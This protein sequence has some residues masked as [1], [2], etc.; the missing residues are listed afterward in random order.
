MK[1]LKRLTV[2]A[3]ALLLCLGTAQSV[4]AADGLRETLQDRA[5]EHRDNIREDIADRLDR[6]RSDRDQNK[7]DRDRRDRDDR[8]DRD[9]RPDP[10]KQPAAKNPPKKL[11]AAKNPPKKNN[12]SDNKYRKP[13][14]DKK[15]PDRK[16]KRH[17]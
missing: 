3:A 6:D 11:P 15:L 2:F 1:G 5:E 12:A 16:D 17:D 7:A 4:Q 14:Q 9:H 8:F 13:G 10:K